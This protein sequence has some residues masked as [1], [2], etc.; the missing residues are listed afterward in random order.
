MVHILSRLP[1]TM[2][3]GGGAGHDILLSPFEH[4]R[5]QCSVKDG[6]ELMGPLSREQGL[7]A[8]WM[9]VYIYTHMYMYMHTY[10][11]ACEIRMFLYLT[12]R[13]GGIIMLFSSLP[14]GSPTV[15][16]QVSPPLFIPPSLLFAPNPNGCFGW[17]LHG[18]LESASLTSCPDIMGVSRVKKEC[19][20]ATRKYSSTQVSPC[21]LK[22]RLSSGNT[23]VDLQPHLSVWE[24]HFAQLLDA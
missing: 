15:P 12:R 13:V 20:S 8:E 14:A 23:V 9:C 21:L 7:G 18:G 22:D 3:G 16:I 19:I 17:I 6:G 4:R 24:P 10:T 2:R 5:R 11:S 1:Q